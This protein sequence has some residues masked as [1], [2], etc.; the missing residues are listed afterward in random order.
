MARRDRQLLQLIHHISGELHSENVRGICF[1]LGLTSGTG[2]CCRCSG[3]N[4]ALG[5]LERLLDQG[6]YSQHD[7]QPLVEVLEE[8]GRND[9]A[10]RCKEFRPDLLPAGKHLPQMNGCTAMA[11]LSWCPGSTLVC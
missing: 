8:V 1:L 9:L 3:E 10:T 7:L 11:L 2:G 6:Y 4:S 5:V